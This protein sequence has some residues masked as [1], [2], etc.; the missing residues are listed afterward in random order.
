MT[1][2]EYEVALM[3]FIRALAKREAEYYNEHYPRLA[4]PAFEL[5]RGRKYDKIVHVRNASVAGVMIS[6]AVYCFVDKRS[7]DILKPAS[8]TSVDPMKYARGNIF[9]ADPLVG[10]N[11]W[12]VN[13]RNEALNQF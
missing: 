13:Y 4:P 2:S 1:P 3:A 10:T 5:K 12:G 9:N 8:Y 11:V 7:G 6:R